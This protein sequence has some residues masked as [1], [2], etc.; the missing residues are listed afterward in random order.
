MHVSPSE[1]IFGPNCT[2]SQTSDLH[3]GASGSAHVKPTWLS[4][5]GLPSCT[6][7]QSPPH[8]VDG[9]DETEHARHEEKEAPFP[10]AFT[11]VARSITLRV[12]SRIGDSRSAAAR[13]ASRLRVR[14]HRAPVVIGHEGPL[15]IVRL[16]HAVADVEALTRARPTAVPHAASWSWIGHAA[17]AA[18]H[19]S[20]TRS[21]AG[22]RFRHAVVAAAREHEHDPDPTL[23]A[24]RPKHPPCRAHLRDSKGVLN[25]ILCHSPVAM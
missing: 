23:H 16:R 18:V 15:R 24:D 1:A 25:A 20:V 2:P 4:R 8:R 9:D 19:S 3:P 22:V 5:Q 21:V 17:H 7:A 6:P 13:A 14:P 12:R 11:V 10:H